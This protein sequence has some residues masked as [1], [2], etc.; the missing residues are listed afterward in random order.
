MYG[1]EYPPRLKYTMFSGSRCFH[2]HC[3]TQF[4]KGV[5]IASVCVTRAPC[6]TNRWPNHGRVINFLSLLLRWHVARESVPMSAAFRVALSPAASLSSALQPGQY[7]SSAMTNPPFSTRKESGVSCF[8]PHRRVNSGSATSFPLISTLCPAGNLYSPIRSLCPFH[9]PP[10]GPLGPRASEFTPADAAPAQMNEPGRHTVCA[11]VRVG[12]SSR[13]S[14]IHNAKQP[15]EHASGLPGGRTRCGGAGRVGP[16][17]KSA[18]L[19][20]TAPISVDAS[21]RER[22]LS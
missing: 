13:V 12:R 8:A 9:P 22:A 20:V 2:F 4:D 10:V 21:N 11:A 15:Q 14:T 18:T 5:A 19:G 17:G 7:L 1:I 6:T 16:R 3:A